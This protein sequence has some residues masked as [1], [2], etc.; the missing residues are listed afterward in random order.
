MVTIIISITTCILMIL[1]ILFFPKIKI[2]N[3]QV[4]SYWIISLLGAILLLLLKKIDINYLFNE[5]TSNNSMNPI[6]ILILFVSMTFLSTYLDEVGLFKYIANL[7]V[8]KAGH[9]QIKLFVYL[10][11]FIS[12]LTV[13][14]SNDIII[15][16]FT[17]FICYFSKNTKINPIPF[18]V[19]EFIAANTWSLMFLIGN[20]TNI[21]IGSKFN[22]DFL[23]YL[24][25]MFFPTLAAGITSFIIL[26]LIFKKE[27]K[28]PIES[29]NLDKVVFDKPL[30]IIGLFHLCSCTILLILSAYINFEMWLI[31][32]FFALSLIIC[33]LIYKLISKKYIFVYNTIRRIPYELIPFVLSMF[34][35][36]LCLKQN[37]ITNTISNLINNNYILY[38]ITSFFGANLLNNIPMS[39]LFSEILT[40]STISLKCVFGVILCSNLGA[41][42]TP[43]G[44]LAGIMWMNLLK[45]YKVNY[46]FLTFM[47]YGFVISIPTLIL[48][49]LVLFII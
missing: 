11:I 49:S 15:L 37:N 31:T 2:G 22:I 44:A 6:K 40:T 43:I 29:F 18:L 13:F 39:V 5:L 30:L 42:L 41:I 17:P 24:K 26:F 25:N 23:F 48:S 14:T 45:K 32:L 35:I 1:S 27:L 20:P 7:A 8:K 19:T 47:K 3:K 34:T 33:T 12:I 4:C 28:K 10:Y 21:Y 46:S 36:V 38:I 9:S 16:T